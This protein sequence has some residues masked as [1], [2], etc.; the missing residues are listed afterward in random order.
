M[1]KER[2]QILRKTIKIDQSFLKVDKNAFIKS[3][4]D[5]LSEHNYVQ[6][7]NK[8]NILTNYTD[9][10]DLIV[11]GN[12]NNKIDS[13][14]DWL[15][16]YNSSDDEEDDVEDKSVA[17]LLLMEFQKDSGNSYKVPKIQIIL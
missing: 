16:E 14:P 8:F 6:E 12:T 1:P 13:L 17:H 4:Y 5:V 9:L 3:S 7:L 2:Q 15:K 11:V 10:T